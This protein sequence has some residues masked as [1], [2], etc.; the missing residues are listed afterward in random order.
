MK[1]PVFG[2]RFGLLM[3]ALAGAGAVEGCKKEPPPKAGAKAE[4]SPIIEPVNFASGSTTIEA[5]EMPAID[6]AA[7][8]MKNSDWKVI[9]LGLADSSG[10]AAM[11][12]ELSEKRAD[13]V[14]AELRKKAPGVPENRIIVHAIGEKLSTGTTQSERKVE[15]VFFHGPADNIR[16]IVL[17]SRVLEE[18]FRARKDANP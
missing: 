8:I 13:V 2:I 17:K 11:N 5:A 18:D 7:D 16:E 3:L 12:K 1:T 15:F 9:V 10:D 14:A 4:K 6:K